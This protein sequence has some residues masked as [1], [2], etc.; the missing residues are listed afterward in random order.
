MATETFVVASVED[1][2]VAQSQSFAYA[3]TATSV[4]LIQAK[5]YTDSIAA[6]AVRE[7]LAPLVPP[8]PEGADKSV[9]EVLKKTVENQDGTFS[10][11]DIHL[12]TV[13]F[14]DVNIFNANV[15]AKSYT[16]LKVAEVATQ[17][18][19]YTD[20]KYN[21][22]RA[23]IDVNIDQV[24]AR[25]DEISIMGFSFESFLGYVDMMDAN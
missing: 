23:Y 7:M 2:S 9:V 4:T 5:A 16:N 12:P 3:D 8:S 1:V 20:A 24:N 18:T 25:I 6:Q 14:V 22:N 17:G 13:G 21:L 10:E 19:A 11:V 15:E